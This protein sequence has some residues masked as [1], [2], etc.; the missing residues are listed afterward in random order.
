VRD[1]DVLVV[2]AGPAGSATAITLA[3]LGVQ[4]LLVDGLPKSRYWSGE[5]LPP[6]AGELVSSLFGA[7]ILTVPP[8]QVAYGTRSVWGDDRL[9]ETDFLANPL[10]TGWQLD[11]HLFDAQ[12]IK[13]AAHEGVR[14]MTGQS[15]RTLTRQGSGWD[16]T[17][18]NRSIVRTHW[19]VDASGRSGV[20][21]RQL[22]IRRNR[23]DQQIG[24]IA[25]LTNL[26]SEDVYFGTMV[27]AVGEGWWYTTPL[28]GGQRVLAYMT[29]RD[30]MA[31]PA[32]R[33]THWQKCLAESLQIRRL[34]GS[35]I[36]PP[37][38]VVY[39]ADT[40][41]RTRLYGEGWAA[42]GDAAITLDPLSSQGLVTAMLMGARAAQAI[43]GLLGD[44]RKSLLESWARDYRMLLAEH[45]SMR[46]F[47]GTA[48]V[49][50]PDSVYWG[51][52]RV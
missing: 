45:D 23:R 22:G 36:H 44:G 48:E 27:E 3:R 39:P 38:I 15:V 43:A 9:V 11:R 40:T 2:G 29:D 20:V 24:Q 12:L 13:S 6:G 42:V 49:R 28:P 10:G 8:H 21:M 14:V 16:V 4:V 31:I 50:W 19:L 34:A 35:A 26:E 17:F 18:T 1:F 52:R 5:S 46:S 30:L 47:Y 33:T 41:E 32:E 25:L 51:R 7:D 37:G